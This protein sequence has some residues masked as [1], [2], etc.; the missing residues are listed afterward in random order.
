MKRNQRVFIKGDN[1]RGAEIIKF[2]TDLGG[3]IG[4]FSY[5]GQNEDAIYFINP[6]GMI[7]WTSNSNTSMILPYIKEF[8]EE[9]KLP[10]WKPKYDEY[11][12]YFTDTQ[13]IMVGKWKNNPTDSWRYDFGN[14][15][16]SYEEAKEAINKIK[17]VLNQ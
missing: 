3:K 5:N 9:I 2:L 6:K 11:Y 12:Y 17:N 13:G 8:Y 4:D 10:I 7:D 1:K 15:F 16:K 14:C